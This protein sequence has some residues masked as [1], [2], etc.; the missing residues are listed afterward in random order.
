MNG[1]VA[2]PMAEFWVASYPPY[3]V[4]GPLEIK[5]SL[6]DRAVN[7][8]KESVCKPILHIHTGRRPY[9]RVSGCVLMG[10]YLSTT[11]VA[12]NMRTTKPYML[13]PASKAS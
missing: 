12:T 6:T 3:L 1:I 2:T 5:K 7:I 4:N 9:L 13:S 11:L 8:A 10:S